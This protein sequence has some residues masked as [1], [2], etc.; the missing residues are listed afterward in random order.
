MTPSEYIALANALIGIVGHLA[1]QVQKIKMLAQQAGATDAQ[2]DDID[3][4][5]T[6]ALLRRQASQ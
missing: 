4:R 1:V 6:A 5:L 2:L 3:L